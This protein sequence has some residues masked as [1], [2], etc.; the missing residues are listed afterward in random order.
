MTTINTY[1]RHLYELRMKGDYKGAIAYYKDAIH[2][3]ISLDEIK[4]HSFLVP[5]L[6]HCLR[7]NGQVRE[8]FV[9]MEKQLCL[10]PGA[11]ISEQWTF[12]IGWTLYQVLKKMGSTAEQTDSK[13]N[14]YSWLRYLLGLP[15]VCNN[16]LLWT[17]LLVQ[18]TAWTMEVP[19]NIDKWASLL[20]TFDP[21]GLSNEPLEVQQA[22]KNDPRPS[23]S[24]REQHLMQLTKAL[25]AAGRFNECIEQCKRSLELINRFHHGNQLWLSRR[26]AL[27]LGSLGNHE[28]AIENLKSLLL[29]KDEWFIRGEV[30][31]LFLDNGDRDRALAWY[32]SA[33]LLRGHS[34]YKVGLYQSAGEACLLLPAHSALA[35]QHFR[36]AVAVRREKN[37]KVP[38]DL[39]KHIGQGEGDGLSSAMLYEGL[40]SFW[41]KISV[42]ADLQAKKSEDVVE[43][44]ITRILNEGENG[45]GFITDTAGRGIYFRMKRVR[46]ADGVGLGDRVVCSFFER[47][48]S[49]RKVLNARWVKKV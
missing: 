29:K 35:D 14:Y 23:A 24:P 46:G 49:G 20:L 30:G 34:E 13:H 10:K 18:G 19:A 9:F 41:K 37:W 5:N 32:A 47:E 7:K 33:A 39:F 21:D 22:G 26:M 28:E 27:S 4:A 16:G 40:V 48:F 3:N 12:E 8:A 6:L 11:D 17:K 43:G 44:K 25:F 45:D 42:Q 36:L 15:S 2:K 38:A 1:N 31:N